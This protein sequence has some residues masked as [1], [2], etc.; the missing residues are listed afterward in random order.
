MASL[1]VSHAPPRARESFRAWLESYGRSSGAATCRS[2]PG[3]SGRT[4][5]P[6]AEG[7]APS[8]CRPGRMWP[9]PA[10][11]SRSTSAPCGATHARC[12]ARSTG[13][14]CGRS[15][16]RT[17][18][19]TARST[20]AARR[21]GPARPRSASPP[22][23]RRSR[24]AASSAASAILVMGPATSR[25][26]AQAREARLELAVGDGEVPEGVR[27]HLKLDTG[28]GRWGLS[29][30]P[31]RRPR[32]RRPDDPPRDRRL[33]PR[34]HPRQ[35]ERFRAATD[36]FAHLTRHIANSAG[37]L[38][39]PEARFDA[40]RCGIALYG[41]S[42]FGEDPAADGLEPALRWDCELAQVKRLQPG[43]STGYGRRYVAEQPTWIG[44]RAGRL[45]GR[46]PA[47]PDRDGGACRGEPR[48]VVG[49]VSMDAFAVELDRE[50]PVGTPVTIVG[51]GRA[52]P[53]STRASPTRSTTSS[54]AAS[55]RSH[56]GAPRRRR[57]MSSSQ[58]L[59]AG[60]E[61]WVVGGAVRDELLGRPVLDLDVACREPERAARALREA[62]GRRAVP[63]LRA[64]RRLA[65]RAR[66]GAHGR[67]HAA[68][69]GRS[70]PTSPRATSR[71]TR[72]PCRVA[73]GEPVDPY[74]GRADLEARAIR[75]VSDTVFDDDPLRLLRAV[76]LEDELDFRLDGHT[77]ELVAGTCR[78]G[79]RACRRADPRRAAP[80]LGR[81]LPPARRAR[82][83]RPARRLARRAARR[84]RRPGLPARRRL[85][86]A[87]A[88]LPDLERPRTATRPRCSAPRRPRT[89]APR[90]IHRFRRATEPWALDALAFVGVPELAPGGRG[91][92]DRR[93]G[94]A[95][96]A[97]RRARPPA[98]PGDRASA[99]R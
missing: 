51:H 55:T 92:A 76:R 28:M 9:W 42:P 10:R 63:A 69:R 67:L 91:S 6:H 23:R 90:A 68:A 19:A 77:E 31:R 52:R 81:R 65:G 74:G 64:P 78:A 26:I 66:G 98:G 27:V 99:R 37:A 80:A 61:A 4:V 60:E 35:I 97:R 50:L 1:L 93:S 72:S 36:A 5:S 43:E 49:T 39:Y 70:R 83:A 86:R 11:R 17:A 82:P 38:R 24:C 20:S 73:G 3:T 84:A 21:S 54:P 71:S 22:C 62:V 32:G 16:R 75:A 2:W 48:R 94:R 7:F 87:A 40:A 13:R 30:L 89:T 46:L 95:A 53:R 88:P 59:L 44:D 34:L 8:A 12:C 79:R 57:W 18:T 29:E 45:R 96:R 15:S 14:S 25:E 47:R 58:E 85:R 33:G 41:L 56:A